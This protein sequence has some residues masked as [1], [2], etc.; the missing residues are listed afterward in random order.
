MLSSLIIS[1]PSISRG[2]ANTVHII[3]T[4]RI[5]PRHRFGNGTSR[6]ALVVA[7][8][9]HPVPVT[10]DTRWGYSEGRFA[11][12]SKEK[13]RTIVTTQK[14]KSAAELQTI[15]TSFP[16]DGM[17][18][19]AC[20]RRVERALAKV[21]GVANA[22]VVSNALRLRNFRRPSSAQEILLHS[23]A[24]ERVREWGYLAGIAIVALLI[25]AGAVWLGEKTGLGVSGNEH[26][27]QIVQPA[28][29]HEDVEMLSE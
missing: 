29:E 14:L 10:L 21:K 3:L 1:H 11:R 20:V 24:A 4:S 13:G 28:G 22:S 8:S 12:R 15:E 2:F 27:L 17:T 5:D 19:A 18:C 26:E 16:V 25:G 9:W 6:A 7:S 23:P